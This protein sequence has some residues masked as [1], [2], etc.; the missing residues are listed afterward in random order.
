[1]A[2]TT[3]PLKF[4]GAKLRELE[5]VAI[6]KEIGEPVKLVWNR[7]QDAQHGK[8]RPGGFHSFKA[9]LDAGVIILSGSELP[10]LGHEVSGLCTEREFTKYIIHIR[11]LVLLL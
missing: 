1:M 7:R 10:G 2:R 11:D 9:A 3:T 4:S 5:A 8:Y 6:S